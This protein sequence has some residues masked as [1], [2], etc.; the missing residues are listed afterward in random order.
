MDQAGGEDQMNIM[1]NLCEKELQKLLV[2]MERFMVNSEQ[3][4]KLL[5]TNGMN[6]A[7]GVKGNMFAYLAFDRY[8]AQLTTVLNLARKFNMHFQFNDLPESVL[9]GEFETAH[10]GVGCCTRTRIF[11]DFLQWSNLG[12]KYGEEKADEAGSFVAGGQK[13]IES[14]AKDGGFVLHT[15]QVTELD[16]DSKFSSVDEYLHTFLPK[17]SLEHFKDGSIFTASVTH[18]KERKEFIFYVCESMDC[19][20]LFD[21]SCSSDLQPIQNLCGLK[22]LFLVSQKIECGEINKKCLWRA[23]RLPLKF[24]EDP[25]SAL[26]I[27]FGEIIILTDEYQLFAIPSKFAEIPPLAIKCILNGVYDVAEGLIIKDHAKCKEALIASEYKMVNLKVVS[28]NASILEV[29]LIPSNNIGNNDKEYKM[30]TEPIETTSTSL[31]NNCGIIP[32]ESPSTSMENN[33]GTKPKETSSTYLENN[34]GSISQEYPPLTENDCDTNP[35]QSPSTSMENNVGTD[36]EESTSMGKNCGRNPFLDSILFEDYLD[37]TES[38]GPCP[39]PKSVVCSGMSAHSKITNG[40]QI[41]NNARIAVTHVMSPIHF[42]GVVEDASSNDNNNDVFFW[43]DIEITP[44]QRKITIEMQLNDIILARYTKDNHWYRAKIIEI[45]KF[46]DQED[47]YKVLYI[48]F[49]N[50]EIISSQF[51]AI[52]DS[53]QKKSPPQALLFRLAGISLVH[54]AE[55]YFNNSSIVEGEYTNKRLNQALETVVVILLNQT[56]NVKIV[57]EK[58]RQSDCEIIVDLPDEPY[59]KIPAILMDLGVVKEI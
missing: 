29:T 53:Q 19:K 17:K 43:N 20:T 10:G 22:K 42:Y 24:C 6:F 9:L 12:R 41:G 50:T 59:S 31:K 40:L 5:L 32:Q 56:I 3:T 1:R 18:I 11:Q 13:A 38:N 23:A 7:G 28:Q 39:L 36:P 30:S 37:E 27:D 51:I 25:N 8:M 58:I 44:D 47:L 45:I 34:C 4:Q 55:Q 57:D 54:T 16:D 26:L 49:G 15:S 35:K 46:K 33:V 48:D 52:C 21:I 2:N 14:K